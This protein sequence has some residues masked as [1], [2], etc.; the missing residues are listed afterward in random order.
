MY[1]VARPFTSFGKFYAAGDVITD[2]STVRNSR[3]KLSEGKLF[4]INPLNEPLMIEKVKKVA[5]HAGL[6]VD[7]LLINTGLKQPPVIPLSNTPAVPSQAATKST[8]TAP[9]SIVSKTISPKAISK[10]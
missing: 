5:Y 3:L 4:L 9:K 7:T 1:L 8:T 2:I 10:K 6:D